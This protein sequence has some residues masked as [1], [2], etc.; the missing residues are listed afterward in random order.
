MNKIKR[1]FGTLWLGEISSVRTI[2]RLARRL[3]LAVKDVLKYVGGISHFGAFRRKTKA[4]RVCSQP[5]KNGGWW[6]EDRM[7]IQHELADWA[8]VAPLEHLK[9]GPATKMC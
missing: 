4:E 2:P 5:K 3:Q 6:G 7:E 8:F 1:G 9:S